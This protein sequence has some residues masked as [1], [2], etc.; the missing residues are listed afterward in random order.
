MAAEGRSPWPRFLKRR[1]AVFLHVRHGEYHDFVD[2]VHAMK[3][4]IGMLATT[5]ILGCSTGASVPVGTSQLFDLQL[6]P[7][8]VPPS[9]QGA[10]ALSIVTGCD[11]QYVGEAPGLETWRF[12]VQPTQRVGSLEQCVASLKTQPGVLGV[13]A[14]PK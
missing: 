10:Y 3:L 9:A 14:A 6:Q 12:R 11:I 4:L 8:R 13:S 7:V 1:F 5:A 2:G